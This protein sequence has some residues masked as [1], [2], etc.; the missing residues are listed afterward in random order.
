MAKIKTYKALAEHS[1]LSVNQFKAM[2]V[3]V[4]ADSAATLA[5]MADDLIRGFNTG[6]GLIYNDDA[7]AFIRNN[8]ALVKEVFNRLE[9][10]R[11]EEGL[12]ESPLSMVLM[13]LND[14]LRPDDYYT[15][16][17]VAEVLYNPR[18]SDFKDAGFIAWWIH[19]VWFEH[20]AWA[21]M[22]AVEDAQ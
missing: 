7:L 13:R 19:G 15:L 5:G 9:L 4:G 16:S 14:G 10:E 22:R 21:I 8:R 11:S 6:I 3:V 18:L 1:G 12:R 17:D 20:V 2:A